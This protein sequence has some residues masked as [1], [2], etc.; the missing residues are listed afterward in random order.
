[1][2]DS[3]SPGV[4]AVRANGQERAAALPNPEMGKEQ[5]HFQRQV[6]QH[7]TERAAY[8]SRGRS[9]LFSPRNGVWPRHEDAGPSNE[10][11]V[12]VYI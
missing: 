9:G 11:G 10:L 3:V 1:M 2:G 7:V 5:P 6:E 8:L 4:M 12:S